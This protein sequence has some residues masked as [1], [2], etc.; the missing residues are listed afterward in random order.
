MAIADSGFVLD[1]SMRPRAPERPV[2]LPNPALVSSQA[3]RRLPRLALLLF[4]AAYVLPGVFGRDPWK[5][6]DLAAVGYM[7][8]L[9]RGQTDWLAPSL[10]GLPAEGG[11]LP[12][13]TGALSILALERWIDPVLAAR[14]PFAALLAATLALIWYAAYHF[15]RTDRAQ[16]LPFAFGGEAHPVDYARAIADAAVLALIASLGLLQLGHETTPELLQ[17]TGT[18]LLL[19][20]VAAS[21]F[22]HWRSRFAVLAALPML[23]LSAA[24]TTALCF[25]AMATLVCLRSAYAN[26]RRFSAWTAAA[27]LLAIVAATGLQTWRWRLDESWPDLGA[28]R[29]LLWFTWPV[30]PLAAW[31]LWQWR[32]QLGFRHIAAPASLAGMAMAISLAM[33]GN[34]RALMLALPG[35]AVLGAFALPTLRRSVSAAIDW[36]S[37]FFFSAAGLTLWVMYVAVHT[38]WPSK[39]AANVAK[40]LPGFVPQFSLAALLLALAGTLAWAWLVRWR[41]GHHR[42]ALWKSLVLPAGGVAWG[43]LL[44]MTLWLPMLDYARSYRPTVAQLARIVPADACIVS[45]NLTRAQLAAL[46]VHGPWRLTATAE[47]ARCRWLLVQLPVRSPAPASIGR[48]RLD[49][50][51]QLVQRVRRLT[52]RQESLLVYRRR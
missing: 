6:A 52:D 47:E 29:L 4:C 35:L 26:V 10:I 14:L 23:A 46:Q 16:P 12:Y 49:G 19:Y 42:Q 2:N 5:N 39:P 48:L 3:V 20:G 30:W 32:R 25:G 51:W 9:A 21:P 36:F 22:R 40:L 1:G 18:A 24:A 34:D 37:V 7:L 27:A 41:T 11:L 17:L 50:D 13:W 31:T 15:A 38:G 28:L 45:G 43:W 33:G 44:T 8:A